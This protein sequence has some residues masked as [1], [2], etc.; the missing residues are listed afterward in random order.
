M[1]AFLL[2]VAVGMMAI[3]VMSVRRGLAHKTSASVSRLTGPMMLML[4]E[5]PLSGVQFTGIWVLKV[6][7]AAITCICIIMILVTQRR[8]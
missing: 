8:L 6:L 3:G 2:L 7:V 4:S 5:G 1:S